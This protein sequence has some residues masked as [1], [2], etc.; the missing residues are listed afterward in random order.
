[1]Y[2]FAISKM[3][4][5]KVPET[6]LLSRIGRRE[7]IKTGVNSS[8]RVHLPLARSRLARQHFCA[9]RISIAS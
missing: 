5:P 7:F 2:A 4:S 9:D 3:L 8:K 1:V 6:T